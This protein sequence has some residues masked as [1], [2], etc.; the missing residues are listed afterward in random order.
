MLTIGEKGGKSFRKTIAKALTRGGEAF[1]SRGHSDVRFPAANLGGKLHNGNDHRLN[2]GGGSKGR[3]G[4]RRVVAA[5]ENNCWE[6][7]LNHDGPTTTPSDDT[8]QGVP[9]ES[10][11]C[12][13]LM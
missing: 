12:L 2:G 5:W 4:T 8:F 6:G 7:L 11:T 10:K 3:K 13:R 1:G 9:K